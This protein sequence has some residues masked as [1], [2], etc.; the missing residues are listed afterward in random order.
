M[1]R[2]RLTSSVGFMHSRLRERHWYRNDPQIRKVTLISL[3]IQ[4]RDMSDMMIILIM[5]L[6]SKKPRREL[7]EEMHTHMIYCRLLDIN[8]EEFRSGGCEL[9]YNFLALVPEEFAS[10]PEET[11]PESGFKTQEE[12]W[13]LLET[14]EFVPVTKKYW[15]FLMQQG[16]PAKLVREYESHQINNQ[17]LDQFPIHTYSH[18]KD[19]DGK[20]L[21]AVLSSTITQEK[22]STE[23]SIAAIVG[24]FQPFHNGHLQLIQTILQSCSFIKIGIGSMQYDH[25]AENPFTF[26]ERKEMMERALTEADIHLDQ[27]Q[28]IGIPDLHDMIRWTQKVIQELGEFDIFYSNSDWTRQLL[29]NTGK[30]V[31]SIRKI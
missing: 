24:R 31:R 15:A 16:I 28:I 13:A 18:W 21:N 11:G 30:T 20:Q 4:H 25:T 23:G 3:P 9:A 26:E 7:E 6:S 22:T 29:A 12:L 27:F 8:L 17:D 10:D 19:E 5:S 2:K 1:H 14:A